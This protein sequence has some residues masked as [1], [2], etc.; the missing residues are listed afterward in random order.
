MG[1]A[2]GLMA[3]EVHTAMMAGGLDL[4]TPPIVMPPGKATAAVNY[5]P[6]ISGYT[7]NGGYERFDG[8]VRPSDTTDQGQV[9]ARRAA[10]LPVPGEGPVR[11]VW[12]FSGLVYAFRDQVG[13]GFASMY[14]STLGG[15]EEIPLGYRLEFSEGE[16][17]FEEGEY[18]TGST[19]NAIAKINRIVTREG[20]WDPT[21][22]TASGYLIISNLTGTFVL[23]EELTSGSGGIANAVLVEEI[24]LKAGGHY[25]FTNHNFYGASARERMYFVSGTDTGYE[26]SSS[27][28]TPIHT[29]ISGT[30]AIAAV[31]LLSPPS[32]APNTTESPILAY[33]DPADPGSEQFE[34]VMSALFDAPSFV[35]HYKNHLFLGFTSGTIINSALGEPLDFDTTGGA[36]EIAFGEQITGLLAAASTALMIFAQNRIEYLAGTDAASF[37]LNPVTD[38]SGAQPYT[39]QMMDSPMFLDDGGIRTLPTTAAFGDWRMGSVTQTIEALIRQK[40]DS[41][42]TPV[43]SLKIRNKD[44]YKLFWS[45]GTGVT[46][47]VG[48]KHPEAI[49]FKLPIEVFCACSGEVDYGLGDRLFV[50]CQDGYVYELNRG[51]SFDGAAIDSYIRLPFNS[52][53]SPSQHTRW[54]KATF[55]I[56]SPDDITMGVAFDVDYARGLGG[57]ATNVDVDAGSPIIT[58]DAYASVDWTQPVQGRLEYHLNG[59]GPNIAATLIHSSTVARQHTISAQTYNFSRRRLKR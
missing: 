53:K 37:V 57:A 15:W 33:L 46:V 47:Y 19:S 16:V 14:R 51:T 50:G 20:E 6:D 24:T 42:V 58:T 41:G 8:R 3:Q 25:D 1:G 52:A 34:I 22:P 39:M 12:V 59:I 7:S 55:E 32:V 13:T 18:V 31:T 23:N 4:V 54:M 10:I 40:R 5:E 44:Q 56:A 28:L 26:W 36:G 2:V 43:A 27:Y 17:M 30:E 49:P 11:G 45:D 21:T 48:R 29:G 9:A 38:A 35:A